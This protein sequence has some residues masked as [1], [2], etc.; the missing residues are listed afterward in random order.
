MEENKIVEPEILKT[1]EKTPE[2]D[3]AKDDL[4]T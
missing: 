4:D 1:E 2:I 3:E